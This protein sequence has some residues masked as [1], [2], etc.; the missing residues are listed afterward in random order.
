MNC[1]RGGAG[2]SW[3]ILHTLPLV[4]HQKNRLLYQKVYH[5]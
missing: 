2:V 5:I 4:V 3:K 1:Q